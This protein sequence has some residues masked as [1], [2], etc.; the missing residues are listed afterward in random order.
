MK[1]KFLYLALGDD[2]IKNIAPSLRMFAMKQGF[3]E[4]LD[5]EKLIEINGNSKVR[6]KKIRKFLT[7]GDIAKV[8]YAYIESSNKGMNFVDALLIFY[9]KLKKVKISVFIRDFY[10]LF[11]NGWEDANWKGKI[12][13][14]LWFVN[15]GIYKINAYLA[16]F[17]SE[18]SMKLL[19]FK[20]KE[21]LP[22]GLFLDIPKLPLR[23]NTIFYAGGLKKPYNLEPVLLAVEKLNEIMNIEFH[24]F[25]RKN[26]LKF[27][28][29]WSDKKWLIIEHKNL[30][31][32]NFRPHICVISS[33]NS[34]QAIA[35]SVKMLDYI[36]LGSPIIISDAYENSKF[37]KEHNIGIIAAPNDAESFYGEL[38]KYFTDD[39][40]Q[41]QLQENVQNLQ[42][43]KE[44]KW[45]TRCEK[46]LSDLGY[47]SEGNL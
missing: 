5:N 45:T 15:I 34:Y 4:I 12:A 11:K 32:L 42:S 22:P 13:N 44:L 6:A 19:K 7:S 17:P 16:Y 36:R 30:Y 29:K 38:K 23:K 35:R 25:C 2:T 41:N 31:D 37:L 40:L 24:L 28:K 1:D 46:V 39:S 18:S 47:L 9:L 3:R 26:D 21:I 27:I 14:I 33:D 20:R 43:S 10:P 8:G